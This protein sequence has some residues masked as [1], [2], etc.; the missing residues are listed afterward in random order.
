MA[1]KIAI[2]GKVTELDQTGMTFKLQPIYGPNKVSGPVPNQHC[3]AF[4]KS[5]QRQQRPRPRP[6]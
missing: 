3:D 5:V 4:S 1:K 2:R 6:N